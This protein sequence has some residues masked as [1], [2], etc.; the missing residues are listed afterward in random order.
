VMVGAGGYALWHGV[1]MREDEDVVSEDFR[2][3]R[4]RWCAVGVALGVL[5]TVVVVRSS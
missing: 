1:T 4:R 5:G 2:R 3:T